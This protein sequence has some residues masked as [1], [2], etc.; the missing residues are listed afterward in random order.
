MHSPATLGYFSAPPDH[1]WEWDCGTG[2]GD[3]AVVWHDD[4]AAIALQMELNL[5]LKGLEPTG[6]PPMGSILL[7]LDA[8]REVWDTDRMRDRISKASL[9]FIGGKEL[10]TGVVSMWPMVSRGLQQIRA[11]PGELRSGVPAR[12]RLLQMVFE[13]CDVRLPTNLSEEVMSQFV[14]TPSLAVFQQP[15]P[16]LNGIARLLRDLSVLE[17]IFRAWPD[18]GL[19]QRLRTGVDGTVSTQLDLPLDE[20]AP[21]GVPDVPAE[22]LDAL[23]QEGGELAQVAGL[24]RHMSAILH[25][26]KPV[27]RQE[28]LPVGGVSDIS[29]RG[30]PSRLLMT[31]LAWDDMTFA[32]RLAQGEALYTRRESPPSEPP[33]RRLVLLDT[34][35]FMWGKPRLFGLGAA[36][37]LLRQKGAESTGGQ[38]LTLAEGGFIPVE[39]DTVPQVR[40]QLGRL[41]P[42]PHVGRALTVLLQEAPQLFDPNTE[43]FLITSPEGLAPVARLAEWQGLAC[44][45]PLHSLQVDRGG[46]V[47]LARHSLAGSRSLS[48]AR[49][50]LDELLEG[51]ST[52]VPASVALTSSSGLLPQFY[53]QWPW[54][55]YHPS[56]P[57]PD[58]AFSLGEKGYVGISDAQVV[59]WWAPRGNN[60][61]VISPEVPQGTLFAVTVDPELSDVVFLLFRSDKPEEV[62]LITAWLD[63][64]QESSLLRLKT[65]A[66][67]INGVRMQ[68]GALIVVYETQLEAVSVHDGRVIASTRLSGK[69]TPWFDGERFQPHGGVGKA[70]RLKSLPTKFERVTPRRHRITDVAHVGFDLA[71][72][73]LLQKEKGRVYQLMLD[74]KGALDWRASASSRPVFR[75]LQPMT[76][77]DWPDHGLRQAAFPDG[78]RIIHDP[79]GFLHVIDKGEHAQEL[80]V[81]LVKGSTAAWQRKGFFYGEPSLLWGEALGATNTLKI[82]FKTLLREPPAAKTTSATHI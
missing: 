12:Q 68:S 67:L 23:E 1:F 79:R 33:P 59:C 82:L 5:L 24:V 58:K 41:D 4:R 49:I 71:G 66:Y 25:V 57:Q 80:S 8:A 17:K 26:P 18:S 30:D 37:A 55:L 7:V 13:D 72:G 19:E 81:V 47:V 61:R 48:Q 65:P 74:D 43:V 9:R 14:E 46:G 28:E 45:V 29:N 10:P 27:A 75:P 34:G 73:L 44:R 64:R 31:E 60:G 2:Q 51:A 6:L 70:A 20:L 52:A 15:T 16:G 69:D 54:P 39:L 50:D 77:P 42:L 32:V 35:I 53:R 78:R 63:G 62:L 22:L 56:P 40:E 36:L 21:D 3:E 76:L 11:L 38:V